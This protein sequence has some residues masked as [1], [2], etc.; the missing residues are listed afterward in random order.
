MS[1]LSSRIKCGLK[2]M[3]RGDSWDPRAKAYHRAHLGIAALHV[4]QSQPKRTGN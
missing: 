4:G 2:S 1:E 3:Y